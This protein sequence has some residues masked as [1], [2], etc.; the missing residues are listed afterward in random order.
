VNVVV[1][2]IGTKNWDRVSVVDGHVAAEFG[3]EE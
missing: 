2:I 3:R 1:N